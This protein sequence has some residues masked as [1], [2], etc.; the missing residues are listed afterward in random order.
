MMQ[1][2]RGS[3]F[4]AVL[5]LT[6][7]GAASAQPGP[8]SKVVLTIEGTAVSSTICITGGSA[9]ARTIQVGETLVSAA[10]TVSHSTSFDLLPGGVSRT[11]DD[12]PLD[13]LGSKRLLHVTLAFRDGV[14]MLEH[15][16]LLPGA[17]PVK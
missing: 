12:I 3:A 2:I 15:A 8:C 13:K 10:G 16:L 17:T 5:V 11:V 6:A 14:V 1:A 4:A 7:A 9:A